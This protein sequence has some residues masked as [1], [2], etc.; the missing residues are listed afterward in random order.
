MSE[1]SDRIVRQ[2]DAASLHPPEL[3]IFDCDGVLVD[4]EVLSCRI[5][6][7]LLNEIGVSIS[8]QEIMARFVGL[9]FESMVQQISTDY[10]V[11]LPDD[12]ESCCLDRFSQAI[13]TDL[14]A[15]PGIVGM[16]ERMPYPIC[17]ASSSPLTRI[18]KSLAV[19]G[20]SD[21]FDGRIFSAQMVSRGKPAPDLFQLA[22]KTCAT[23]ATH[24]L[25]IED[26]P[27]GIK[28]A[29]AA[30]MSCIGFTAGSHCGANQ[31]AILAD[32]GADLLAADSGQ[33]E[34][35][36]EAFSQIKERES[37]V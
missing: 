28:A 37:K 4:S 21:Y 7:E 31:S 24:C 12:F 22:A 8:M 19:T 10:G 2:I 18:D 3:V 34:S 9:N 36:L 17:L 32:A 13:E 26:S 23:A 33:L 5:E 20:L 1:Y 25:V 11:R 14:D 15:V 29:T 30:G 35:I 16:L 6:A 27:H